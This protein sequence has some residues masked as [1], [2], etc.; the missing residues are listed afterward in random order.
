MHQSN[1]ENSSFPPPS[2]GTKYPTRLESTKPLKGGAPF[3]AAVEQS[4]LQGPPFSVSNL[5]SI[6]RQ[7][8]K[9]QLTPHHAASLCHITHKIEP[10]RELLLKK[11]A[12]SLTA[13]SQLNLAQLRQQTSTS[14]LGQ[15][16]S[17]G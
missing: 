12:T 11:H 7:V 9:K 8:D 15:R 5:I 6:N 1:K 17:R 2:L 16:A 4:P 3:T 10:I 13:C 14:D